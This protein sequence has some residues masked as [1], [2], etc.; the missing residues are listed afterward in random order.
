MRIVPEWNHETALVNI[1]KNSESL[2]ISTL[3]T[4]I[5]KYLDEV[6]VMSSTDLEARLIEQ[7]KEIRELKEER[8]ILKKA[9]AY[10]AAI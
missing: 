2:N 7:E 10:F 5:N 8:D 6:D 4:W 1:P 9:S 3:H